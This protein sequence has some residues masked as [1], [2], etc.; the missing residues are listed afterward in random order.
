MSDDLENVALGNQKLEEN[1][2]DGAKYY[3][4]EI[5]KDNKDHIK[6]YLITLICFAKMKLLKRTMI[7]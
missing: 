7:F 3:F 4:H 5:L 1:E 6:L 2:M